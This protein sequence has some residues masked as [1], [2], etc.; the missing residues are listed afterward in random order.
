[1]SYY[2]FLNHLEIKHANAMASNYAIS[3]APVMA[4][5]LFAHNLA[6]KTGN[7]SLGVAIIHHHA[8]L[9]G[10]DRD[11][12]KHFAAQQRKAATYIDGNDYAGSSNSL[13]LQ[14]VA[15]LHL[16]LS[17]VV[18]MQ[19]RPDTK[20]VRDFLSDA[21]LAGGRIEYF[22]EPKVAHSGETDLDQALPRTGYWLLERSDL[23][24][25]DAN[26]AH[27]LI[28]ALGQRP[29]AP[30]QLD[31]EDHGTAW[32]TPAVLGY[33]MTTPFAQRTGVR[34]L[35]DHSTPPHAFAEPL[36]GLA[37]YRSLRQFG[38]YLDYPFWRL[39]WLR[40]DVFVAKCPIE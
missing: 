16:Q 39:E 11:G 12:F 25:K 18:E 6:L 15:T 8:Q 28:A 9:L 14:P 7:Q 22:A 13:S 35:D 3:A 20:A 34:Q 4:T 2:L 24:T 23:L 31:G 36:L 32:L 5:C 38:D 26:P 1:M 30:E 33:A 17:L 19:R 37:Q 21:R 29:R 40:D 10:E 27:A